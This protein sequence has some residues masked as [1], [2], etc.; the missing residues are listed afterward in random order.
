ME[1]T[2]IILCYPTLVDL[3]VRV[4]GSVT[5]RE[6]RGGVRAHADLGP[7]HRD[8]HVLGAARAR[9]VPR[10][11]RRGCRGEAGP[12]LEQGG[13]VQLIVAVQTRAPVTATHPALWKSNDI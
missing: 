7:G 1:G 2:G 10:P 5:Q 4:R 3:G 12:A 8:Q 13:A 6:V 11:R 9:A